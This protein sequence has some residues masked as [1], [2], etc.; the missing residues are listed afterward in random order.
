MKQQASRITAVEEG[1][2]VVHTAHSEENKVLAFRGE[3]GAE[4]G[5]PVKHER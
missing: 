4:K 1:G 2:N 3:E 5:R